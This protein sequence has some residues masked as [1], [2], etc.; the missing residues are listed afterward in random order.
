MKVGALRSFVD[1]EYAVRYGNVIV[2]VEV[3]ASSEALRKADCSALHTAEACH[4]RALALPAEDL[5]Y[6]D[7]SHRRKGPRIACEEQ[8]ELE[9]NTSARNVS[10]C[11]DDSVEDSVFWL[12]TLVCAAS[13]G[14]GSGKKAHDADVEPEPCRTALPVEQAEYATPGTGEIRARHGDSPERL[15]AGKRHCSDRLEVAAAPLYA[16]Q[17]QDAPMEP[18]I[19]KVRARVRGRQLEL[20]EDV[21]LP[22]DREV[23]ESALIE[24][25]PSFRAVGSQGRAR[26]SK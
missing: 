6:E 22:A 17:N 19:K 25:R 3:Q 4:A 1:G 2:D 8:T 9:R 7:P 24:F 12:V 21:D 11:C 13:R 18:V 20:L 15:S 26:P 10:R 5:L 14:R 23:G 16:F